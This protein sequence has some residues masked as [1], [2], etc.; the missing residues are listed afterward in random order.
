MCHIYPILH[1]YAIWGNVAELPNVT[2]TQ[3]GTSTQMC[4]ANPYGTASHVAHLP[5]VAQLSFG[6]DTCTQCGKVINVAKL[7]N[8]PHLLMWQTYPM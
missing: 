1:S 5:K 3:C 8:L 6:I 2:A 4:T 7:P